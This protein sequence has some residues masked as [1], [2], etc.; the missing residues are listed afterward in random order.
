MIFIKN[1]L[2]VLLLI[3]LLYACMLE[4]KTKELDFPIPEEGI[5]SFYPGDVGIEEHPS[6]IFT[7]NFEAGS[8]AD[9]AGRWTWSRGADDHRLSLDSGID[10]PPG[11]PGTTSLKMTVLRHEEGTSGDL[12]N[13][14]DQGYQKLHLRF[15]VKFAE[16]YGFNHHFTRIRGEV[17][18]TAEMIGGA[19]S[20]PTDQFSTAIDMMTSNPNHYPAREHTTPPGFWFFYTYWP[21]MRSY[22]NPDGSGNTFYGNTF[23]PQEP[24]AVE[25][26]KWQ[27]VEIMIRINSAPD[28]KD[29][30]MALW[31]DGERVGE[32]DPEAENPARGYWMR[33]VFRWD[34]DHPDAE[35]FPGFNWRPLE[36]ADDFEKLKINVVQLHHYVSGRTWDRADEYAENNPD[37]MIN[38]EEATVW[39]DHV[40]VATD[41]IGP[42]VP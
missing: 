8:M 38:L 39:K 34:P 15:Y 13:I 42:M 10:G 31:I 6:V 4:N 11:T 19:G 7:E 5:A 25:R 23:M 14:L 24:V 33:D 32:W 29:G 22:E 12:R 2:S 21:Q 16:D 27:C 40:V 1:I 28:K 26:G 18:P 37:F 20:R 41:F 17:N 3:P 9:V 35:D 30:A 36:N